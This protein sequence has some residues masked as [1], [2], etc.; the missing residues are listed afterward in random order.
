M[1]IKTYFLI[2]PDDCVGAKRLNIIS[3]YARTFKTPV[4]NS[5]S[6]V[7]NPNT[8]DLSEKEVEFFK[9]HN[10]EV[11]EQKSRQYSRGDEDDYFDFLFGFDNVDELFLE[12]AHEW[13]EEQ[14]ELTQSYVQALIRDSQQNNILS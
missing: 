4:I 10:F 8:Y 2:K 11:V 12:E 6:F 14:D 13:L 9:R 7:D 1:G 3:D 5:V